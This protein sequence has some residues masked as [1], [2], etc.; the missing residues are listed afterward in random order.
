MT[1]AEKLARHV[2]VRGP[3]ECW[4]WKASTCE[5]YGQF[6]HEGGKKY[7]HVAAY[8]EE[9]GPVPEGQIVRHTCDNRPC[10]NPGHLQAGTYQDNVDDMISRGRGHWQKEVA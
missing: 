1:I 6:R 3:D 4:P 9:H 10:C 8:E 5:G 7:A 2:D